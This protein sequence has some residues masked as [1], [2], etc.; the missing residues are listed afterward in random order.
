MTEVEYQQS[1]LRWI[2]QGI[3]AVEDGN[4]AF[5]LAQ[6]EKVREDDLTPLASSYLAY[7]IARERRLGGKA[8]NMA[9]H[10]V[11]K[12]RTHPLIYLNLGRV[13]LALGKD[14]KALQVY[15]RGLQCQHHPLLIRQISLIC[16]RQT[17][18]FPFLKRSNLLNMLSGRIRAR[19][20]SLH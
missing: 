12:D 5:A 2:R 11:K 16:P 4:I 6:L 14:K 19:F 3:E 18:T 17:C 7:C 15:R 8:I 13:Y 20:S 1:Y 9:L 10:A